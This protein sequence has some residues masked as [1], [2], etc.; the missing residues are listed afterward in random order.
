MS[1][2]TRIEWVRDGRAI[3]VD[4]VGPE[5]GLPVFSMHSLFG[6]RLLPSFA[7]PA[8]NGAGVWLLSPDRPGIGLSDFQRGRK[9]TDWPN[10]VVE[11]ADRL[12]ID[13]F[14]VF[15]VSAGAP[16]ALAMCAKVPERITRVAIASGITPRDE[17]GVIHRI[18][19]RWMDPA[20][21]R[22]TLLSTLVHTALIAGI[23]RS[24][25]RAM[26]SLNKTLPPGDQEVI[27]RPEVADFVLA[28]G[29]EAAHRGLRGW[30]HDD[31]IL[32]EPWGFE[33]SEIPPD[34]PIDLYWGDIDTSTPLA[35]GQYLAD[36]LPGATLHV[37]A[38][39]GH[40]GTVFEYLN[41]IFLRLATP[42]SATSESVAATSRGVGL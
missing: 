19:P 24:P 40:F 3:A 12:G 26:D 37:Q 15:G 13:R 5:D 42:L 4:S 29:L 33:L 21:K 36:Q 1:A 2:I 8:A 9:V 16:Y 11:I 41:E 20:V 32:N 18:I 10:D 39:K 14:G 30:A 25:E 28:G 23:R 17:A 35:H 38:G 34:L 31:R 6:C 27:N 7:E 22:S